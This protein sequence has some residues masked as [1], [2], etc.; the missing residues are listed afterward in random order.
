MQGHQS[1]IWKKRSGF[2]FF[3]PFAGKAAEGKGMGRETGVICCWLWI[4]ALSLV[5]QVEI[6]NCSTSSIFV[7]CYPD[8]P[9]LA[10]FAPY[11]GAL[12]VPHMAPPLGVTLNGN[13][14]SS[15]LVVVVAAAPLEEKDL[16]L[17]RQIYT[18][19]AVN[20]NVPYP[21]VI[22]STGGQEFTVKQHGDQTFGQSQQGKNSHPNS[23]KGNSDCPHNTRHFALTHQRKVSKHTLPSGGAKDGKI[24]RGMKIWDGVGWRGQG[25]SSVMCKQLPC[26]EHPAQGRAQQQ[27]PVPHSPAWCCDACGF[28]PSRHEIQQR[29][30]NLM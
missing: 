25:A 2:F 24:P 28:V 21:S 1:P 10:S 6:S 5:T 26:L 13:A 7:P 4:P 22:A 30:I 14:I 11:H 16:L 29:A 12:Y 8:F 17:S 18:D 27:L 15:H 9:P 23:T 20:L 19:A 3:F